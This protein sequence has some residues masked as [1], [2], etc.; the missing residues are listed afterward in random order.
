LKL[1]FNRLMT[2]KAVHA[3]IF[4]CYVITIKERKQTDPFPLT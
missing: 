3:A 4:S 1:I 2:T